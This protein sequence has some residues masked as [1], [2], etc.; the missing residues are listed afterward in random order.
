[1]SDYVNELD[2]LE[3]RLIAVDPDHYDKKSGGLTYDVYRL[4]DI[5]RN[6]DMR[7]HRDHFYHVLSEMIAGFE[8]SARER[9]RI[10]Q[11]DAEYEA[12][13][14]EQHNNHL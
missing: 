7:W 8:E 6:H 10:A 5:A 1:M 9:E 3:E 11:E 13:L 12:W 2:A 4:L 14:E